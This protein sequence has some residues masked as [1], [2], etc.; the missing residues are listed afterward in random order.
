MNDSLFDVRGKTAL[1]TGAGGVL[2]SGMA[3]ALGARGA[4]V[5]ALGR[6]RAKLEPVV[7]AITAA[8][9]EAIVVE[10]DVLDATSM[11]R[12]VETVEQRWGR[13]DILVNGAG[14]NQPGATTAPDRTFFNLPAE[15]LR[16]VVDLNLMG[17]VLPCQL[18]GR[19]MAE[20]GD[21]VILNI[22]SMS[23]L[24]PLTRVVGYGMAKAALDNFTKWLAVH[25]AQEYSPRLRVN[26]LAPGFFLT[27]QN[28]FLLTNPADGSL[29]ERGGKIMAHTPMGRF[30]APEDLIGAM[31]W[32]VSPA[33]AFV[34]GTVVAVDGGFSAYSGV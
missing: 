26:A 5:A 31:L 15:A 28:R 1:V 9:G 7:D 8:G 32:L 2:M 23:A 4:N 18:V 14:G 19:R 30:G 25:L 13:I 33:S 34:T 21:G 17:S 22:S 20:A 24:R 12:A 27:E 16:G 10:A 3:R 11:Q 6:T 29:T